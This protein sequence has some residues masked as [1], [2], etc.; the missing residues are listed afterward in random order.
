MIG[1]FRIIEKPD[2]ISW[3]QIHEV[4]WVAHARNRENGINMALPALPGDKIRE[5]VEGH[6]KMLI[7]MDG[8]KVVGT[9]A[10]LSLEKKIWCGNGKY[11]YFCFGSVL[12]EY[13]GHGIY[14]SMELEREKMSVEFGVNRILFDTHEKNR[15]KIAMAKKNG[16]FCVDIKVCKDHYNVVMVKWLNGCPYSYYYCKL[17]FILHKYFRKVKCKLGR[18]KRKIFG[19]K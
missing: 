11:S 12:P 3:N 17:Q 13:E 16:Y 6:G 18:M 7:A 8:E 15:R 4:L 19:L 9:G 14:K 10:I 1:F 5:K 2:S